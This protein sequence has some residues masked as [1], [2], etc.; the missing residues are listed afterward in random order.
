MVAFATVTDLQTATGRTFYGTELAQVEWLLDAATT[1]LRD[2]IGQNVYPQQAATFTAWPSH[3]R[4]IELP[5]QPLISI[6]SVSRAG[7][8]V[9]YEWEG[10][11]YLR[12]LDSV[13]G[14]VDVTVTVGYAQIPPGLIR[15]AIVLAAQA[16]TMVGLGLGPTAGGLSSLA[17]DDFRVAFADAGGFTGLN[18]PDRDIDRLRTQ[19]AADSAVVA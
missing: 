7:I 8:D 2:I 9:Q 4:R 19:F 16:L 6:D 3:H 17:I 10:T 14:P 18:L 11:G 12:I 15:W 5:F 13:P 1:Y